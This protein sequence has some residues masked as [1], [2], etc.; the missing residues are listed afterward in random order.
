MAFLA[1]ACC[2]KLQQ[3]TWGVYNPYSWAYPMVGPLATKL[4]LT[5]DMGCEGVVVLYIRPA[6]RSTAAAASHYQ[7]AQPDSGNWTAQQTHPVPAAIPPSVI[8]TCL[9]RYED[10]KDVLK[11]LS[12]GWKY[13]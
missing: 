7:H 5:C 9:R 4:L 10:V 13:S 12:L 8:I 2:T 3:G 6:G 11:T 1:S